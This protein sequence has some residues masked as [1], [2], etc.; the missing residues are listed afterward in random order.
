MSSALAVTHSPRAIPRPVGHP[1]IILKRLRCIWQQD[2]H[3][4]GIHHFK[5]S[6]WII[7]YINLIDIERRT[8]TLSQ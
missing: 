1:A 7:I 2:S 4:S 5:I 3:M 6:M 8:A